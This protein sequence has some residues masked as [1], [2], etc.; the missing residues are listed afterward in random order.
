MMA[1]RHPTL[2]QRAAVY[3]APFN[4][5]GRTRRVEVADG[6]PFEHERE[7]Y[8]R[9][10]PDP[11]RWSVLFTKVSAMEW[12]GF[13]PEELRSINAPVLVASG[14]HDSFPVEQFVEAF[15]LIPNAQLAIIPNAGHFVLC[16]DPEKVIPIVATF[17]DEPDY[18]VPFGT[19]VTGY[20]P[21]VT[22]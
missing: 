2:V 5:S 22:R 14:D 13:L 19:A 11:T 15:R 8:Q 9:V 20:H 1:V 10:A 17:L 16:S 6:H 7:G 21:G 12:Q 18:D 3:G 4:S